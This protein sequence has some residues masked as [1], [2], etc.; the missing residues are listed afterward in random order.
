MFSAKL[1]FSFPNFNFVV[2]TRVLTKS[3]KIAPSFNLWEREIMNKLNGSTPAFALMYAY[4][5][6]VS[7]QDLE[8]TLNL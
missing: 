8:W 6:H 3:L 7:S 1:A 2:A 4:V 5:Y